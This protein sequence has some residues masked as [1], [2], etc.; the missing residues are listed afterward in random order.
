MHDT[1]YSGPQPARRQA[2]APRDALKACLL[3]RQWLWPTRLPLITSLNAHFARDRCRFPAAG[4]SQSFFPKTDLKMIAPHQ[5]HNCWTVYCTLSRQNILGRHRWRQ[6]FRSN[7]SSTL[8]AFSIKLSTVLDQLS[9]TEASTASLRT[10]TS[11]P[12]S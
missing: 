12:C 7:Y 8:S 4:A 2:S 1:R 11:N 10:C 6:R 3:C 5:H 9:A